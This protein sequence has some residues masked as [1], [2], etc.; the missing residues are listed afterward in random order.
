MQATFLDE[1]TRA[2]LKLHDFINCG[3]DPGQR[4]SLKLNGN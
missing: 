1:A 4:G 2:V 3:P